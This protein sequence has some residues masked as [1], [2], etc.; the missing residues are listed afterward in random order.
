MEVRRETSGRVEKGET[1]V[2]SHHAELETI[3]L[4]DARSGLPA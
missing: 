1:D 3:V 4:I 2:T